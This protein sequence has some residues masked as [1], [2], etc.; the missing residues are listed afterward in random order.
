M[1]GKVSSPNTRRLLGGCL[2]IVSALMMA[3]SGA[4]AGTERAAAELGHGWQELDP[5]GYGTSQDLVGIWLGNLDDRQALETCESANLR[6]GAPAEPFIC[7]DP[8]ADGRF[9]ELDD[10]LHAGF[11]AP[12]C[13]CPSDLSAKPARIR[14]QLPYCMEGDLKGLTSFLTGR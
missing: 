10:Q 3:K 8:N 12:C 7:G 4:L 1:R 11:G 13:I 6:V 2:L 9:F 5:H 14:S